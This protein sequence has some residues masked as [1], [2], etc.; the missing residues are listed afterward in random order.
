MTEKELAKELREKYIKNPP[1]GMSAKDIK[2]M[3]DSDLLDMDYFL[4][5]DVFDDEEGEESFYIF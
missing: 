2:K 3:S 1:E 5:E 4:H